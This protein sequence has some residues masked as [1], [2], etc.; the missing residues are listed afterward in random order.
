M[1]RNHSILSLALALA[2]L[3]GLAPAARAAVTSRA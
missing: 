2:L 3:L 1:K